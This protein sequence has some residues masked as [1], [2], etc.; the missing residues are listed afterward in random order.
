MPDWTSNTVQIRAKRETIKKIK[1]FVRSDDRVFDFQNIVSVV[2]GEDPSEVWGTKWNAR[3]AVFFNDLVEDGDT[4]TCDESFLGYDFETPY[5]PA[6]PVAARLSELFPDAEIEVLYW[7]EWP[8]PWIRHTRTYKAGVLVSSLDE[9][10]DD[11]VPDYSE[12]IA[13]RGLMPVV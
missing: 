13:E 10:D 1:D 11:L 8:D 2:D 6:L 7:N 5:D 3:E 12:E 4:L 9:P